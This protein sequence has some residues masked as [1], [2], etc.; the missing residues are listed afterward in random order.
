MNMNFQLTIQVLIELDEKG[1]KHRK[2]KLTE[3]DC[4]GKTIEQ[5]DALEK[6]YQLPP[7][8]LEELEDYRDAKRGQF[9]FTL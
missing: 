1:V 7:V 3:Q 9:S 4:E 2:Q 6:V 5:L 8:Y